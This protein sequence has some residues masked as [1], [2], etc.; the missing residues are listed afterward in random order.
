M[1]DGMQSVPALVFGIFALGAGVYALTRGHKA[2]RYSRVRGG[3]GAV[4]MTGGVLLIVGAFVG[5]G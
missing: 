3:L 1:H 4:A 5:F 2:R